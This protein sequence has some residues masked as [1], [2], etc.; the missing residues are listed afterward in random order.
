[1]RTGN[2]SLLLSFILSMHFLYHFILYFLCTF[3][4]TPTAF[5][6]AAEDA[7]GTGWVGD[8]FGEDVGNVEFGEEEAS[9]GVRI[10]TMARDQP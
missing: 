2:I 7:A 4:I 1:M 9:A 8:T 6:R 3:F 10:F 5:H